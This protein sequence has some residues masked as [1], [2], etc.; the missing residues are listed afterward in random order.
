MAA[1]FAVSGSLRGPL[2]TTAGL[3][4]Q[5]P[6]SRRFCD[7]PAPRI[8]LPSMGTDQRQGK[9]KAKMDTDFICQLGP[10]MYTDILNRERLR[11]P[12]SER[13]K[14]VVADQ[15]KQRPKALQ[16]RARDLADG[17]LE[18]ICSENENYKYVLIATKENANMLTKEGF[19]SSYDRDEILDGLER[20]K[21]DIEDGR[22][23]WSNNK[24]LRTNIIDKLIDIVGRPAK[25]LDIAIS[26]YVQLLRVLQ[27]WCHDSIDEVI[28]QIK[29]LQIEL[30]LLA[31]RNG[32][33]VLPSIWRRANWILLGD[34]VLSQLEQLDMGVSQLVSCKNKMDSTLETTFPS[35]STYGSMNSLCK[36]PYN[37]HNSV[38]DF[39]NLIVGDISRDVSN[40]RLELSSW[41][42]LHLLT[43]NDKV[44]E[45]VSLM[46]KQMLDLDNWTAIQSPYSIYNPVE[47][48][49]SRLLVLCRN[50]L[51]IL[52][53]AKEFSKEASFDH[54]KAR[55]FLAPRCN[56]GASK[57]AEFHA[58]KDLVGQK[59]YQGGSAI[60]KQ[61]F[62]CHSDDT[63]RKLL[64]WS[65]RLQ[66]DQN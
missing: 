33:L 34:V 46:E 7:H 59:R 12:V 27:L 50:V 29:E 2:F 49:S 58:T 35:N 36:D 17:L 55:T 56:F 25:R 9:L 19:I 52:K 18:Y 66:Y 32:G 44:I 43:P 6:Q 30:I 21:K 48:S 26:H 3:S 28:S 62:K 23:Q 16:K 51:E 10:A 4:G 39:G 11:Y 13:K 24:D 57:L 65:R 37:V 15:G 20:I 47:D 45:S 61:N 5:S 31:I 54:E 22:F 60:E 1:A 38:V 53:A 40:L 64:A 41:M 63:M 14:L 8:P 42:E